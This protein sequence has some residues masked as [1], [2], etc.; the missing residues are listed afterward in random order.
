MLSFSGNIF[1][2]RPFFRENAGLALNGAAVA[3]PNGAVGEFSHSLANVLPPSPRVQAVLA[4]VFKK[5]R[6]EVLLMKAPR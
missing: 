1:I 6:R 2:T 4:V 3:S 5:T